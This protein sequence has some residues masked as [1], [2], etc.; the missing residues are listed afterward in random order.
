MLLTKISTFNA[1]PDGDRSHHHATLTFNKSTYFFN[2]E[3]DPTPQLTIGQ[4]LQ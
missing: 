4:V 1:W 2:I 3:N